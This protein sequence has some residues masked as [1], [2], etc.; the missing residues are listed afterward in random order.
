MRHLLWLRRSA[1]K[2]VRQVVRLKV[3]VVGLGLVSEIAE[4]FLAIP[5]HLQLERVSEFSDHL[6]SEELRCRSLH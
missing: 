3:L 2:F 6:E 5:L 4:T 1:G